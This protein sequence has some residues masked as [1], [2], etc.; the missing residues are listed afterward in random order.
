MQI[1]KREKIGIKK[2]LEVLRRLYE[3]VLVEELKA[4]DSTT[5]GN[6]Y[7]RA[8]WGFCTED[9][10]IYPDASLHIFPDD[11]EKRGRMTPMEHKC[12]CPMRLRLEGDP[13]DMNA[14][15]CFYQ[16][17]IFSP[18]EGNKVPHKEL[19]LE[20]INNRIAEVQVRI[21]NKPSKSK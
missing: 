2:T 16:C 12:D 11:F 8:N 17:R 21:D 18:R 13:D 1:N 20:L 6:K 7:T 4:E 5:I 19:A 10:K 15:G 14:S 9:P 3:V